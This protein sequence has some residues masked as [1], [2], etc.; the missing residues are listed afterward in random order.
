MKAQ[1]GSEFRERESRW[2]RQASASPMRPVKFT[3]VSGEPIE[4]LYTPDDIAEMNY[5]TDLGFPGEYP[6][7]RGIHANMYRGRLWTMR[8]FAGF[9]TP[10]DTNER[11][12]YL[13]SHGQTGLSVAFDLPTLMG[14]DPDDPLSEGEVGICGVSVSSLADMEILFR[15]I[16]LK[17]VSTSMTINAPAAML[18][19]LYVA[20]AEKQ[21]ASTRDLRG[22][23]QADILKEYIAQKEWIYPPR[24]SMRIVTDMIEYCTRELPQWNPISISG[25]HI[26]EAGS[27]AVQELAFTLADGFAYVEEAV[28]R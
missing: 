19:A 7:T 2:G 8:Q 16:S 28:R 23:I 3:T 6:Y 4:M 10:E 22:T 25:Y 26:R 11:Y 14:R 13:L 15:G 5:L 21:G 24:P 18:L 1:D 27:T 12:H 17:D 20:V 9:G